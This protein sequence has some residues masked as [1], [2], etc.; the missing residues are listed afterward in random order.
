MGLHLTG[1]VAWDYENDHLQ[2]ASGSM[3]SMTDVIDHSSLV[4]AVTNWTM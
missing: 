4:G 1:E 2:N 3:H